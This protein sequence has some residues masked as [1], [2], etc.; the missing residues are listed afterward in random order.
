MKRFT[1]IMLVLCV[2]MTSCGGAG[3]SVAQERA[4]GIQQADPVYRVQHKIERDNIQ[5][6]LALFDDQ[7]LVSWIYCLADNGQVVFYGPVLGKVTSSGKRLEPKE[8]A[9]C[10][11]DFCN[12]DEAFSFDGQWVSERMQADGT[13]GDSDSYV[14]W[15][16][17]D[18]NYYQWSG[19]YFLTSMPIKI[20]ESVLNIR[21]VE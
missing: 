14:Y 4:T 2:V 7:A 8:M 12:R 3:P 15:F 10:A 13:F 11:G 5:R 19:D 9:G 16:D 17:P 21:E 18:S 6:R 20:N 1:F